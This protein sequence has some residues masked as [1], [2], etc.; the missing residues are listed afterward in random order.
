MNKSEKIILI[1]SLLIIG[2]MGITIVYIEWQV[3]Q[4]I[5]G[6]LTYK[7]ESGDT[8]DW[9]ANGFDGVHDPLTGSTNITATSYGWRY[10]QGVNGDYNG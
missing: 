6:G 9:N 3:Q 10:P 5:Y 2:I 8:W 4:P 1:I 7:G